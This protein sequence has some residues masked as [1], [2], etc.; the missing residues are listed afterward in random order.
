MGLSL[1]SE[2]MRIFVKANLARRLRLIKKPNLQAT[3]NLKRVQSCKHE[4]DKSW[5]VVAVSDSKT[6]W[7]CPKGVGDKRWALFEGD[8]P[9]V[10]A[11]RSRKKVHVRAVVIKGARRT[12][13]SQRAPRDSITRARI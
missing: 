2:T 8:T 3:T 13:S 11:Y 10:P 7:L 1:V 9:T 5:A 12:C 6:F 4:I